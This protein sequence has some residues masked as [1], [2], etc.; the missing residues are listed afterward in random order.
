M[1]KTTT[2]DF[3]E[4]ARQLTRARRATEVS[5]PPRDLPPHM[6]SR[7]LPPTSP[8]RSQSVP[9]RSPETPSRSR[10]PNTSGKTP[11]LV[12][13]TATPLE[14]IPEEQQSSVSSHS[15]LSRIAKA[16]YQDSEPETENEGGVLAVALAAPRNLLLQ[17]PRKEARRISV[18]CEAL[19][20][21]RNGFLPV[22]RYLHANA[23]KA[24][25]VFGLDSKL[26]RFFKVYPM[27]RGE[28]YYMDASKYAVVKE[29]LRDLKRMISVDHN[30][31][32][33]SIPRFEEE[34]H[35]GP[36]YPAPLEI[37]NKKCVLYRQE[38]EVWIA[39]VDHDPES[40]ITRE[41]AI[42]LYA[43]EYREDLMIANGP[44]QDLQAA[45]EHEVGL[46]EVLG[47]EYEDHVEDRDNSRRTRAVEQD[48]FIKPNDSRK[49]IRDDDDISY[50]AYEDE[51]HRP[52]RS[53]EASPQPKSEYHPS[54][55][56]G[57]ADS[58]RASLRKRY[59]ISDANP[60]R[61]RD[62]STPNVPRIPLRGRRATE[63]VGSPIRAEVHRPEPRPSIVQ[64][65]MVDRMNRMI[66]HDPSRIRPVSQTPNVPIEIYPGSDED[67]G[68][69]P[70]RPTNPTPGRLARAVSQARLILPENHGP[71][72]DPG[73][74]P[75]SSDEGSSHDRP[76]RRLPARPPNG[77]PRPPNPPRRPHAGGGGGGEPPNGPNNDLVSWDGEDE[78]GN[79]I[80]Y[81][82]ALKEVKVEVPQADLKVKAEHIDEWDGNTDHLVDWMDGINFLAERSPL[83]GMQLGTLV[84]TRFKKH[85][86]NWWHTL[87]SDR[88]RRAMTNWENLRNEISGYFMNRTWLDRQ[89]LKA[90]DCHYRDSNAPRERPSEY[91]MRKYKLLIVVDNYSDVELIMSIMEGAPKFWASIIDT[92][93]LFDVHELLEKISYHEDALTHSPAMAHDNYNVLEKRLRVLEQGNR[94]SSRPFVRAHQAEAAGTRG[95]PKQPRP[96]PTSARAN[97]IG[98]SKDLPP[99]AFPRDDKTISKGRTPEEKNARPCRHCGSPKHWDNECK[100]ARKGGRS[101]RTNFVTPSEEYLTALAAYE[102][103]YLETSAD[104]GSADEADAEDFPLD[105]LEESESEESHPKN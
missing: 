35:L 83:L 71:P 7:S 81:R 64:E 50:V 44:F 40:E 65:S 33:P 24:M 53:A 30:V 10:N 43:P 105:D 17:V 5:A 66:G 63:V 103:V 31:K 90:K 15:T 39:G 18:L 20:I 19:T 74:P 85:A 49:D 45:L 26:D 68:G 58:R 6:E 87:P 82:A 69:P 95:A 27:A 57:Y 79:R 94:S 11:I 46:R 47:S 100:H 78:F 56:E 99:P 86:R 102:E 89:K 80:R 37:W 91:F 98:F 34:T 25:T 60:P 38:V 28:N 2:Q 9:P 13:G 3:F 84:P 72:R 54:G 61:P 96:K 42:D 12:F 1:S 104:E 29:A 76:P 97:L 21:Y 75:D 8:P 22:D 55:R 67:I 36:L 48:S 4:S 93:S 92:S 51:P 73:G 101:V 62:S 14:P 88:K 52:D 41:Q 23:E 77:P 16:S 59:G 70:R 32:L